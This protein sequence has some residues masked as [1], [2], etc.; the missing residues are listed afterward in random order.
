M[1]CWSLYGMPDFV[2]PSSYPSVKYESHF[3]GLPCT[4]QIKVVTL[5]KWTSCLQNSSTHT[6]LLTRVSIAPR[7]NLEEITLALA[8]INHKQPQH[9]PTA[10]V[11]RVGSWQLAASSHRTGH[12]A[13]WHGT[14]VVARMLGLRATICEYVICFGNCENLNRSPHFAYYF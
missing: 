1:L 7:F 10:S 13:M 3:A 4:C 8:M 14:D 9:A 11:V 12:V 2:S 5:S 6:G